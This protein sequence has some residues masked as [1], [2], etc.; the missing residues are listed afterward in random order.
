MAKKKKSS[1]RSGGSG[2]AAKLREMG[3]GW[4][5]TVARMGGGGFP[6]GRDQEG[7]IREITIEES[8]EGNLM[9]TW[10]IEGTSE[11]IE[12]M[13]H[14]K[15][16]MLMNEQNREYLRGEMETIGL[17]WP[18][19]EDG[20]GEALGEAEGLAV[21][22]DVLQGKDEF[23]NVYFRER[24]EDGNGSG[25]NAAPE[26]PADDQYTKAEIKKLGRDEDEATLNELGKEVRLVESDYD[27]WLE[28]ADAIIEELGL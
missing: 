26:P 4:K 19:T 27:T 18:D 23:V 6:I 16:S 28:F 8:Q 21:R 22:L 14:R 12:S 9:V 1:R 11:G 17:T 3:K 20:L 7:I 5:N 24:L 15:Q 25:S 2:V 10:M 13:K